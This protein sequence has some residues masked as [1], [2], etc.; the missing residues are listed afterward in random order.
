MITPDIISHKTLE[1]DVCD[2]LQSENFHC[3]EITYHS[4]MPKDIVKRLSG[5]FTPTSLCIR[6]RSDRIAIHKTEDK[7]FLWE[8][9]THSGGSA[10]HNMA[11]EALPLCHYRLAS[12]LGVKCVYIYR[13]ASIEIEGAF[14]ADYS[15]PVDK[16]IIPTRRLTEEGAKFYKE[17]FEQEFPGVKQIP[18]DFC[19]GS[20]DPFII[21]EKKNLSFL[22]DYKTLIKN[23]K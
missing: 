23:L 1:K 22:Q 12:K 7:C 21:I 16:I 3:T 19:G 14:L 11:I 18:L 6:G 8:A 5:L 4:V 17:T 10:P 9:K 2:Y 15:I 13:D 20:G